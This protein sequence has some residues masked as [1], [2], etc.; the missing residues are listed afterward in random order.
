MDE[1]D[2]E[3][4]IIKR[5]FHEL[6]R[7]VRQRRSSEPD[8]MASLPAR[9]QPAV[10][11]FLRIITVNDVYCLDNYPRLR[12]AI[13][14]CKA[15]SSSLDC[16]VIAT[17]NGDFLSPSSLTAVDGGAALMEGVALCGVDFV[18]L[19]NHEF[20]LPLTSLRDKLAKWAGQ[21]TCLNSNVHAAAL[22]S[23]PKWAHVRVGDRH[24]ILGGYVTGEPAIYT[25]STLTSVSF[26]WCVESG[27]AR[28][29]EATW[30]AAK[31]ALGLTPDLFLPLTHQLIGEDR[32]T[33]RALGAHEELGARTPVLLGGHEHELCM[34]EAAAATVVKLG[35]NA[36]RI[37]IVD[38][39]WE[40]DGGMGTASHVLPA[41][42]FPEHA[43][44]AG[45]ARRQ[46]DLLSE[47]MSVPI[48]HL[49][50]AMSSA[51]VR[52][53]PSGLATFLLGKLKAGLRHRRVQL[54]MVQGGNIRAGRAYEAGHAFT[55]GDL[56]AEFAFLTRIAVVRV[57]GSVL[58]A[59]VR[60]CRAAPTPNPS[61][62][63]LDAD[64]TV[65]EAHELTH[66][67]GAPLQPDAVYTVATY[68]QIL[69]GLNHIQPL[70]EYAQARAPS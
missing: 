67:D 58:A 63:H 43:G 7:N 40:A 53:E 61:F 4:P 59:T 69:V 18:C 33:A 5:S 26:D 39:W 25:P 29:C 55:M 14:A 45:F 51:R 11:R 8:A 32:A 12:S 28:A 62:L 52:F 68:R 57:P 65:S 15:A 24:A 17:L 56:Y 27:C 50:T 31:S 49:P 66:I 9:P 23:L 13:D 3:S 30:S 70:L 2:P 16:E 38:V 1:R 48:A 54:A 60:A 35:M 6:N 37:G 41:R 21:V 20:D 36:T 64:A 46:A 19:G 47:M 44:V 10:G 34:E 42:A 22:D